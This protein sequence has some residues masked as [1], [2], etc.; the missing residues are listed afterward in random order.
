[1]NKKLYQLPQAEILPLTAEKTMCQ[2][3]GEI[4]PFDNGG[5]LGDD[6]KLF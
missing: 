3:G 6:L 5:L 2:S 4:P 1:M